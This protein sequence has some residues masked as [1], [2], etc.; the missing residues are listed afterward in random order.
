MPFFIYMTVLVVPFSNRIECFY[1]S[2]W[3]G[4]NFLLIQVLDRYTET[5]FY[6]LFQT[7]HLQNVPNNCSKMLC[8]LHVLRRLILLQREEHIPWQMTY[9]NDVVFCLSAHNVKISKRDGQEVLAAHLYNS[10]LSVITCM[11]YTYPMGCLQD[12][13][14]GCCKECS[15]NC[16][17]KHLLL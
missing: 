6:F 3:F 16:Q 7:V 13:H 10:F 11:L 4:L 12:N 9:E 17:R 15:F 5:L 2:S 1:A 14:A 8:F